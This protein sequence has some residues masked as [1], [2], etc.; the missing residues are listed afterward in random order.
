MKRFA[1]KAFAKAS[2]FFF[3]VT[4]VIMNNLVKR[5]SISRLPDSEALNLSSLTLSVAGLF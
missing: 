4:Q 5:N 3:H 1:V 2:V